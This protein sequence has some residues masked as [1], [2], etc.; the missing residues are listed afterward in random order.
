MA[1]GVPRFLVPPHRGS[2][3]SVQLVV[4]QPGHLC[5]LEPVEG[6]LTRG[7]IEGVIA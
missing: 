3:G 7:W 4:G 2:P 1:F 5:I 6:F